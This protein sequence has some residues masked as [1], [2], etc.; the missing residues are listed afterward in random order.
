MNESKSAGGER[1]LLIELEHVGLYYWLKKSHFRR[2]RF[3]A[4]EDVTLELRRGQSLGVIGRNGAGKTTILHL[5]AGIVTPDRGRFAKRDVSAALLSLQTGFVRY[6]TGRENAYLSGLLLGLERVQIT[7][8]MDE[9]IRFA[10]LERFIDHPIYSY[11][12]GMRARLGFAVAFQLNPDILLIDEVLGVGD[13]E[14]RAKSEKMMRERIRSDKTIVLVS[15]HAKTIRQ[16]C[17]RAVWVEGGV[18]R[19]AGPTREVLE[20][21]ELSTR[22]VAHGS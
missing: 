18:T 3:W 1:E 15:H 11:S 8:R 21:Y 4:L 22:A 14:F 9:I 17:D 6:L 12:A 2:E 16:L 10:G 20:E 5:L 19:A 7:E 13:A